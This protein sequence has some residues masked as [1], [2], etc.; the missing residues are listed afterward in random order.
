MT[1]IEQR[2]ATAVASDAPFVTEAARHL[3]DAG[4]KRFRPLLVLLAAELGDPDAERCRAG[5][6]GRRADP[7]GDA[8]PRRR[9]GRGAA[10]PGAPSANAR[11]DNSVAILI[12]DWLFAQASDIV[13]D[14]GPEAVRIQARTF[15][16]LVQGQIRETT[17]PGRRRPARA[18]PVRGRRQDR[19]ADRRRRADGRA[20]GRRRAR[21]TSS[22]SPTTAS[23]SAR[24]SSCPTTSSTSPATP[25]SPARRR[26]PTCA[27]GC[28]RCRCCSP[29]A[30]TDPADARLRSLLA[31]DLSDDAPHAEA[32]ALL[33]AHPAVD[34]ARDHV[35][36]PG[37]ARPGAARPTCPRALP[38][39]PSTPS[40]TSSSP[41]PPD[42]VVRPAPA[43]PTAPVRLHRSPSA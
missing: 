41:A 38:A 3:L 37:R 17:G 1:D 25:P 24:P 19:V 4:G 12:G 36:Q 40:A 14:L 6:A 42:R 31:G 2:L 7:P 23:T 43:W 11:F 8:V 22:C 20:H 13:A 28:P 39:R 30:P 27:R 32:L 5:R 10:A 9:H 18:L 21:R 15:S 16:R 35:L 33:R 34:E 26:A 29:C